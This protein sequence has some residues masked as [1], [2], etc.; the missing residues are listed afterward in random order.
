MDQSIDSTASASEGYT[1]TYDLGTFEGFNFRDNGAIDHTLTADE[2]ANW[3]HDANGE[4]EFWPSGEHDGVSLL[5]SSKTAVT[6]AELIALDKLLEE[7][8]DDSTS[9]F[10][11]IYHVINILGYDICKLN[12]ET[13]DD[14]CLHIFEGTSF[15]DLRREAAFELFELYYPEEYKIWEK[16]HC[17]GLI[18]DHDRFLDSPSFS[19]EE[20]TVGDTKA[21]IIAP[22]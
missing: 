21:L 15:I 16:S 3:D 6:S 4:A 13:V 9:N 2:V 1:F 18:F 22:Q 5:F 20:V 17:D 10:I 8:G 7:I 12:A 11:R 14:A 19:T